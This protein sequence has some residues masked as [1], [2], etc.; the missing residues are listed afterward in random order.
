MQLGVDLSLLILL[1]LSVVT[2][3][4]YGADV[5]KYKDENGRWVF[6]DKKP[7]KLPV[8]AQK[9]L[10]TESAAKTAIVNRGSDARPKLV[11]VN[12][13]AGPVQFW[14]DISKTQNMRITAPEPH[15]WVV[16]AF[17]EQYLTALEKQNSAL[18]WS[19][20]WHGQMALGQPLDAKVF[21]TPSL[22]LPFLGGKFVISQSFHGE[23]SH[24]KDKQSYFAVDITLPK[25]TPVVAASS[26]VVMDVERNFSRSGWSDDY[27]DE[28]NYVRLLHA[29]GS[30]TLYAHLDPDSTEVGIGQRVT[31]G[32]LLGYSGTTGYSSGPHLHFALQINE[33]QSL[34]S[35]PFL[36]DN[37]GEPKVGLMIGADAPVNNPRKAA[38]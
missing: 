17:S 13:L 18:A 28:A 21:K 33:G 31:K 38:N 36:F 22:G 5:Y 4:T 32:T 19:Y 16:G 1:L 23:A 10:V 14:L 11:A 35:V 37:I 6:S 3:N 2:M 15:Q 7:S 25:G 9:L 34:T 8:K 12:N 27:A 20:R 26:G 29:D 30:M 24:N